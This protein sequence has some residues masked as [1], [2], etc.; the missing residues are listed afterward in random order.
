MCYEK[1][2]MLLSIKK[3]PV[4]QTIYTRILFLVRLGDIISEF[5]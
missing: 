1:F 3:V 4:T 2:F 5:C